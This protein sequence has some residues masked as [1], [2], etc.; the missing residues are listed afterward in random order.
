MQNAEDIY[1]NRHASTILY[2]YAVVYYNICN[3]VDVYQVRN[4]HTYIHSTL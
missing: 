4:K 3:P 2:M 1:C